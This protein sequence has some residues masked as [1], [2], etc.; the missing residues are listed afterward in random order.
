MSK[1]PENKPPPAHCAMTVEQMVQGASDA[2]FAIN[3]RHQVVAWNNSA[4]R[5]FG[6]YADEV[7]GHQCA[8]IL[9]AILPGGEPLCQP[10]CEVYDCYVRC[11][12]GGVPCCRIRRKDGSWVSVCYSSMVVPEQI[13]K[14]SD[15]KIMA[16]IFL[17]E[18]EE[19]YVQ[20]PQSGLLQIFTLGKFALTVNGVSIAIEKWKRKQALTLLKI[21]VINLDRPV[22]RERILDYLWPDVDEERGWGRLKVTMYYLRTQLR[23]HGVKEDA[24]Q[25]IGDAYLLRRDAVLID[26]QSF[27][28]FA[29]EGRM[30]QMQGCIDEALSCY[31]K[32]E[33]LYHGDYMEQDVYADWCAEERGR[34]GE[35]HLDMLSR[36]AECHAHRKEFEEA[37][38]ECRK[39]LI[40]DPC[41]ES[42]HYSL[43]QYL[44]KLN[45]SDWAV[46]QYHH[47]RRVLED[48]LGV[49]PMPEIEILYEKIRTQQNNLR[50]GYSSNNRFVRRAM[51][52][53]QKH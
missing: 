24:V 5:L 50:Q 21:L 51:C 27:E 19:Q 38:Q 1:V 4:E 26:S 37:V 39:A 12:P 22:H 40:Q 48:E 36:K 23:T 32:A 45:R 46:T 14:N 34:L 17:H 49:E 25:T 9:Q 31:Q 6:Y 16:V 29:T 18:K 42:F 41:R 7:V 30:M 52:A 11:M 10:D 43:M 8:E 33:F 20:M 15:E 13:R 2:S 47:C 28:K 35:I 44:V 3:D 53:T